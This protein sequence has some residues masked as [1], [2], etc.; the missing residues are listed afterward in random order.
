MSEQN[1]ICQMSKSASASTL[2]S[3]QLF[4]PD[5]IEPSLSPIDQYIENKT[6]YLKLIGTHLIDIE[7]KDKTLYPIATTNSQEWQKLSNLLILGFISAVETY[8]RSIIRRTLIIDEESKRKSYQNTITY[9]AAL[10]HKQD[11]LPEALLEN[12]SFS[13]SKNICETILSHL[14][15]GI[16][17]ALQ[18]NLKLKSA[19]DYYDVICQL[20][21]CVV[22]RSGLLGSNNAISLGMDDHRN[23]LEKP[24]TLDIVAVQ[25]I[26]SISE[27][28]VIEINNFLFKELLSR[29][30]KTIPWEG[31]VVEDSDKFLPYYS[32][33]ISKEL[34]TELYKQNCY[35]N[36][37]TSHNLN[38]QKMRK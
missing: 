37:C 35:N 26:A 15:I 6:S 27:S 22:H 12:A 32:L 3:I 19:M 9:G 38:Y 31:N 4:N 33:F 34:D 17:G 20:R 11:M 36:F 18:K 21:H 7:T 1:F 24:I 5:Y 28:L 13:S 25:N 16:K 2:S 23:F 14:G 10:H 30:I 8:C 29:T